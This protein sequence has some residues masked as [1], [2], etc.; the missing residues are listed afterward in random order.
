MKNRILLVFLLFLLLT[1]CTEI[2]PVDVPDSV[3]DQITQQ[4]EDFDPL[5]TIV[6]TEKDYDGADKKH[7]I[8]YVYDKDA[9]GR[10]VR[11]RCYL[12]KNDMLIFTKI[13]TYRT[14][15]YVEEM[16]YNRDFYDHFQDHEIPDFMTNTEYERTVETIRNNPSQTTYE[17]FYPDGR[18]D[19]YE[20]L[21]GDG[22]DVVI[23]KN[24]NG[25]VVEESHTEENREYLKIYNDD[26]LLEQDAKYTLDENGHTLT[27]LISFYDEDGN[28]I[29]TYA[30]DKAA[31]TETRTHYI[32]EEEPWTEV[33]QLDENGDPIE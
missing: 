19:H 28:V 26:G 25:T 5:D 12:T 3:I 1:G 7:L 6:E 10:P 20:S 31:G 2:Q 27:Y 29:M 8:Y 11:M 23:K 15:N 16:I 32:G 13:C 22:W 17:V 33:L 30:Y 4:E 24:R 9:E 18:Q 21:D 14:N